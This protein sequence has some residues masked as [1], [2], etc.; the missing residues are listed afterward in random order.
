MKN[1]IFILST[2]SL[3][4]K[5]DTYFCELI[6]GK[7]L[8]NFIPSEDKWVFLNKSSLLSK[9]IIGWYQEEKKEC[10]ECGVTENLVEH[11]P[12]PRSRGG[13]KKILLCSECHD[14]AHNKKHR[15][16]DLSILIKE[17]LDRA[18]AK[19]KILGRKD[20][21]TDEDRA[22]GHKTRTK[23]AKKNENNLKAFYASKHLYEKGKSFIKIADFL[24]DNGYKTRRGMEW[25]SMGVHNLFMLFGVHKKGVRRNN[26]NNKAYEAIKHFYKEKTPYQKMADFL[27]DNGYKTE[28]DNKW[29]YNNVYNL[30]NKRKNPQGETPH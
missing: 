9:D 29:N 20:N 6:T 27:N 24:N 10:L 12:I 23:E 30:F 5:E 3:P 25:S 4:K 17:G 2:E 14:K 21:L 16:V 11:H 13:K 22:K 15:G 1:L 18:R 7:S 19:G 28:S 26:N 8:A